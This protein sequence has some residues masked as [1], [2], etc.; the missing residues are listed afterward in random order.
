M[1]HAVRRALLMVA[2]LP[3]LLGAQGFGIYEQ[4]ACTMG[5]A[6]T[7]VAAPCPNASAIFF[8]PAGLAGLKGVRISGGAT[9]IHINGSFT[10]DQFQGI[11]NLDDP[12][13]PVP[14]V[15]VSYGV[16]PKLGVGLGFF[17]PYGLQTRWPTSFDGRFVGYDNTIKTYYIQ[18]TVAYQ[19]APWLK[20]GGGLDIVHGSVNLHQRLD[21]ATTPVPLAG[22]PQGTTFGAFGI[23]LGTDFAD[24]DLE[25]SNTGYG[26]HFGAIAK[27]NNRL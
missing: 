7:A 23:P 16:T 25:A 9:L 26:A 6:G 5:R 17:A 15:F 14:Q 18:P 3:A 10:D 13:I 2:G 24:A 8:N 22:L 27:V 1:Q 19:V 11:T 20:I 4:D 12:L 21:L